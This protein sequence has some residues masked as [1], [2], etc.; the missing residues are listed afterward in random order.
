MIPLP[1]RISRLDHALE[2]DGQGMGDHRVTVAADALDGFAAT[3]G[4]LRLDRLPLPDL[5]IG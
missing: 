3:A 2:S 1:N 5:V 4:S